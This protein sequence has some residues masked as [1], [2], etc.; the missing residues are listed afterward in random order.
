M[1]N[2]RLHDSLRVF[3]LDSARALSED[4]EAGAEVAFELDERST[5]R[6]VL[7]RYRPL[8]A[9]F[10]SQRWQQLRTLESFVPTAAELGAGG[11][12]CV[13]V[14]GVAADAGAEP[15]LLAMLERIWEDATSFAFPEDRFE[16]VYD[17]VERALYDGVL[18]AAIAAPL[19]G[20]VMER[21]RVD[22]GDGMALIRGD[23]SG[24]PAEAVWAS[25][26]S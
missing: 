2:R 22:L 10:I 3:A 16:K 9:T 7:Y 12:A 24:A 15:A 1:R 17:E 18:Q 5:G 23:L 26:T 25:S 19:P 21:D 14:Q 4:I 13:R 8:I 6:S 11:A 20:L